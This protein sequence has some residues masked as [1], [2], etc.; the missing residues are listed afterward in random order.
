MVAAGRGREHR[1]VVPSIDHDGRR[2]FAGIQQGV[3]DDI[4]DLRELGRPVGRVVVSA[5]RR[6]ADLAVGADREGAEVGDRSDFTSIEDPEGAIDA[7]GVDACDGE[8]LDRDRVAV[9][10]GVVVAVGDTVVVAVAED[11]DL[12]VAGGAV[13]VAFLKVQGIGHAHRGRV[14]RDD[15]ITGVGEVARVADRDGGGGEWRDAAREAVQRRDDIGAVGVEADRALPDN[16]GRFTSDIDRIVT[17]DLE[18]SDRDVGAV[19]EVDAARGNVAG[20]RGHRLAVDR[21][22]RVGRSVVDRG[23]GDVQVARLGQGTI[24]DGVRNQRNGTIPVGG[25]RERVSTRGGQ[26]E[27]SLILDRVVGTQGKRTRFTCDGERNNGKLGVRVVDVAVVRQDITG[28]GI[29]LVGRGRVVHGHRCIIDRSDGQDEGLGDDASRR[30][31]A[32]G[33][34]EGDRIQ[35]AVPVGGR[36]ER[37]STRSGDGEVALAGDG[38]RLARGVG[39]GI[40]RNGEFRDRDGLVFH[41]GGA[42]ENITREGR[43]FVTRARGIRHD[44][45]VVHRVDRDVQRAGRGG[46]RIGDRELDG[47]QGSIP[48]AVDRREDVGAVRIEPERALARDDHVGTEGLVDPIYLERAGDDGERLVGDVARVIGIDVGIDDRTGQRGAFVDG[49]RLVGDAGRGVDDDGDRRGI[50]A[51]ARERRLVAHRVDD[52]ADITAEV[53]IRRERQAPRARQLDDTLPRDGLIDAENEGDIIDGITGDGEG[54]PVGVEVGVVGEDVLVDRVAGGDDEGVIGGVRSVVCLDDREGLGAYDGVQ[55]GDVGHHEADRASGRRRRIA[56]VTVRDGAQGRLHLGGGHAGY[57]SQRQLARGGIVG[58][59]QV[60]DAGGSAERQNVLGRGQASGNLNISRGD[61]AVA[62]GDRDGGIH[63]DGVG[64]CRGRRAVFG[65]GRGAGGSGYL[66]S[67]IRGRDRDSAGGG[68][69]DIVQVRD[70]ERHHAVGLRRRFAD[71]VVLHQAEDR[72]HFGHR[73]RLAVDG[74][75]GDLIVDGSVDRQLGDGRGDA[76]VGLIDQ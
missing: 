70:R 71:V 68:V 56:R 35:R 41:V 12:L 40:A 10:V 9:R 50:G 26:V 6:V 24:G 59:R 4:L 25:R 15:K 73:D 49:N 55:R 46:E 62:V 53:G 66:R 76:G 23:D 42:G 14:E 61:L 33:S 64:G 28:G 13:G 18:G 36:R 65:E 38:R 52:G 30:G 8:R 51:A 29:V 7:V 11:A 21:A 2:D 31:I 20:D 37:V 47:R 17:A 72:L 5:G 27:R 44:R 57:G 16:G 3:G 1:V 67:I 69:G 58:G 48:I 32:V 43:V 60:A 22:I 45:I 63:G 54:R 34:L 19:F 39:G 75:E 74:R